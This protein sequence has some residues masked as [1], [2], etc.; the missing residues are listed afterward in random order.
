MIRS[1]NKFVGCAKN[2][3][4]KPTLPAYPLD[5]WAIDGIGDVFAI[6]GKQEIDLMSRGRSDV[7][8]IDYRFCWK[9]HPMQKN[10]GELFSFRR[11]RKKLH[12]L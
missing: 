10:L 8:G 5:M 9:R 4:F 1:S 12:T 11:N 3:R 6:P 2:G 7:Q